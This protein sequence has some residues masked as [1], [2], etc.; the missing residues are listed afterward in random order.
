MST[1]F[2]VKLEFGLFGIRFQGPKFFN[3]LNNNTQSAANIS[4][5]KSRLKT[6]HLHP[7]SRATRFWRRTQERLCMNQVRSLLSMRCM[8]LEGYS[9][10]HRPYRRALVTTGSVMIIDLSII[11]GS[12]HLKKKNSFVRE[13]KI[14]WSRRLGCCDLK[15]F[16]DSGSGS[17]SPLH[18][19][20]YFAYEISEEM[21]YP[22]L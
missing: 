17:F 3:S 9:F 6:F 11:L 20:R 10:E 21:F 1:L 22:N 4:L 18:T 8:L 2:L 13:N 14:D 16:T 19:R 12:S 15:V 5:F 7:A